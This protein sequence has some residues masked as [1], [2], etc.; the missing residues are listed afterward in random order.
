MTVELADYSTEHFFAEGTNWWGVKF[1]RISQDFMLFFVPSSVETMTEE[2]D[3]TPIKQYYSTNTCWFEQILAELGGGAD[4]LTIGQLAGLLA[5]HPEEEGCYWLLVPVIDPADPNKVWAVYFAWDD[6]DGWI[7]EVEFESISDPREWDA[8]SMVFS[9]DSDT[10][11]PWCL[12]IFDSLAL[13]LFDPSVQSAVVKE[14]FVFL[15][16]NRTPGV[17]YG[18]EM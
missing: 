13:W 16:T 5:S 8:V 7:V 14:L 10:S 6:S 15:T 11:T 9:R 18:W 17:R 4:A 12:G 1:W 2:V 3:P